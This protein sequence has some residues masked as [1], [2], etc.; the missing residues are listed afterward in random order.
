MWKNVSSRRYGFDD[1]L[2]KTELLTR[3][4]EVLPN[5]KTVFVIFWWMSTKIPIT[6]NI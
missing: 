2:L 4:P 1:L 6:L 5:T 3:F